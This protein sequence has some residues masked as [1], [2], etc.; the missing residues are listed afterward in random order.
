MLEFDFLGFLQP[1]IKTFFSC[2]GFA[3]LSLL[4]LRFHWL[5]MRNARSRA[6][7]RGPRNTFEIECDVDLEDP[8][9]LEPSWDEEQQRRQPSDKR[10]TIVVLLGESGRDVVY[11]CRDAAATN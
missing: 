9:A 7:G 1:V 8:V 3:P 2:K 11:V 4:A 6:E 5:V 10:H